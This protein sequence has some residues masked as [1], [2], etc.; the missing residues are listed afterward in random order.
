MLSDMTSRDIEMHLT[1]EY[2]QF[3]IRRWLVVPNV[4]WGLNLH[5]CDLLAVSPSNWAHEVEIKIS[6]ADTK[7]DRDKRHQHRSPKI[8][9]LWFAMP[10]ELVEAATL[11]V[12]VEAGILGID[13]EERPRTSRVV[14]VRPPQRRSGACKLMDEEVQKLGRLAAM[15]YWGARKT[16]AGL[17]LEV[18]S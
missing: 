2:G 16:I 1:A 15:R 12:P 9:C 8:V 11:Y 13:G 4:S 7:R 17:L 5:E 18:A 3:P 14:K 10:L 6:L